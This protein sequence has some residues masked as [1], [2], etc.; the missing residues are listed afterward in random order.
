MSIWG[1]AKRV[2]AQ[3]LAQDCVL[4]GDASGEAQ[5]CAAC[6]RELPTL[7]AAGC[8]VCALPTPGGETCG[9]CLKSPPAF[10]ASIAVWRYGFPVDKLVQSLKFEHRL[11]LA[12]LFSQAMLAGPRP[13]ADL[14][15]ALPLSPQRLAERGFNQ[16]V[17]IARPLARALGRPLSRD[18]CRRVRDTLPQ[19]A[20]PWKAR[21]EN[22]RNAFECGIDLTGRTVAVIDDV[23]TTGATLGEFARTLKRH[24]AA[25]VTNWVVA[26]AVRDVA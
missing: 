24:G 23:M 14:V 21:R 11:P 6:M 18:D 5:L 1:V 26:R 25:R 9:A 4:C 10:D 7:P 15:V 2:I 20:L 16:A 3:A 17:E 13:A 8:P 19:T 12:G 22:V